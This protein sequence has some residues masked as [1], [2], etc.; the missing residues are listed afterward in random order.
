MTVKK[1]YRLIFDLAVLL[2]IMMFSVKA[3]SAQKKNILRVRFQ[4][5]YV[6]KTTIDT[7]LSVSYKLQ[8]GRPPI[9]FNGFDCRFIFENTKIAPI[10]MDKQS[11]FFDN[12]ACANADFTHG[13]VVPPDEYRVQVLS[14]TM[15][16]TSNPVLFQIRY[17][18]K[19]VK[20]SA[21][22]IP[23][24]FNVSDSSGIDSVIIEN[25]PG[26]DQISWFAFG[27]MFA[28]TAKAQPIKRSITL[29]SDTADILSDS[30]KV[31]PVN[32][33][34]LDSVNL[35]SGN[36]GF[37]LDT[38]AFDSVQVLKGKILANANLT[39]T[40]NS[41]NVSAAFTSTDSLK[42]SGEFLKII[43]RGRKRTDT[44]CTAILNP[45]LDGLNADNLVSSVGY[46]LKSI[47]VFGKKDT[48]I[49]GV[50][51]PNTG[52]DLRTAIFP[53]PASSFIDF[54]MPQGQSDKKH[55]VV[56]DALGREV[57][58]KKFDADFRWDVTSVA[59]GFYT[60]IVTS[61]SALKEGAAAEKAKILIIH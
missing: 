52:I 44:I 38:S 51:K 19:G 31:I 1:N 43:L 6:K 58:D 27:L 34:S 45:R 4:T 9:N 13:T 29:L 33:T 37:Y 36:F 21:M 15:L 60:A 53:N 56:F 48:I 28:D 3:E 41:V 42:G 61:T 40:R 30:I 35:K 10:P 16:D 20:D 24:L 14:G 5:A 2:L 7:V 55:L 49:K 47:C 8:V 57:Y 17:S 11:G 26:R 50:A 39:V 32:V 46:K 25:S 12:T 59:G 22:I 18:V 23:T 54:M